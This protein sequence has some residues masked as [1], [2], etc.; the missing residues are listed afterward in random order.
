[1]NNNIQKLL[2]YPQIIRFFL[3]HPTDGY[4]PQEVSRS[5]KIS[6][7]TVWRYLRELHSMGVIH[8]T[9]IGRYN[10][11]KLNEASPLNKKLSD[12][13][14]VDSILKEKLSTN[15]NA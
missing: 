10:V 7:P 13:V 1:M 12:L 3:E 15:I 2:K 4:T 6:Y 8:L 11:Y 14:D 5:I 9:R